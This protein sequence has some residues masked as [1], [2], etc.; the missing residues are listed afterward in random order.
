ML[1]QNP[2]ISPTGTMNA[3]RAWTEWKQAM[4]EMGCK[5]PTQ[6]SPGSGQHAPHAG[7]RFE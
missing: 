3:A 4:W 7:H 1:R 6:S 2:S 5:L